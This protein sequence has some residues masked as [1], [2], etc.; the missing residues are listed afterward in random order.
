M[1]AG[2]PGATAA[3]RRTRARAVSVVAVALLLAAIMGLKGLSCLVEGAGARLLVAAQPPPLPL[4]GGAAWAA[5]GAWRW[6]LPDDLLDRGIVSD[7]DPQA[8][9]RLARKML[10]GEAITVGE[11]ARG[12]GHA[13]A[14]MWAPL[15]CM[16]QP[17]WPCFLLR[18]PLRL[19]AGTAPA[20]CG[21]TQQVVP[22]QPAARCA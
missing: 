17:A 19:A 2:H 22:S 3:H 12:R 14:C 8:L 4:P 5:P 9:Q 11:L 18:G 15:V 7:G 10:A 20:C 13:W 6:P 21:S 1:S 16:P